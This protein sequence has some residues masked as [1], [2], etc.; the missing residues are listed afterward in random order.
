MTSFE[1]LTVGL[2]DVTSL[3]SFDDQT[4]I[5]TQTGL[6]FVSNLGQAVPF[7]IKLFLDDS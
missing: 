5:L 1:V 6:E 7:T 3:F 2:A 4:S